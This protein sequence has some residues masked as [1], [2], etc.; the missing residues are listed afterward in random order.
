MAARS[1]V[2]A[3]VG[4]ALAE[5]SPMHEAEYRARNGGGGWVFIHARGRVAQR[6]EAGRP[7]ITAD[8]LERLITMAAP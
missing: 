5:G 1:A 3:K 6:D 4:A 8:S 7:L 2:E